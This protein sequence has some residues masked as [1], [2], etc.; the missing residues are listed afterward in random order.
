MRRDYKLILGFPQDR[1]RKVFDA[2]SIVEGELYDLKRDPREWKNL[3]GD[4]GSRKI[5][6]R[7]TSEL[8]AHLAKY[9]AP[10][11]V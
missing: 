3:Y 7:M 6:R 4:P 5:V 11:R 9:C 2:A 8:L 1:N 10:R